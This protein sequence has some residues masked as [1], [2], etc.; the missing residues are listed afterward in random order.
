M[1]ETLAPQILDRPAPETEST[2]GAVEPHA[3]AAPVTAETLVE[4]VSIDG[5]CGVY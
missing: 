5:M 1:S 3:P 2:G 4:E